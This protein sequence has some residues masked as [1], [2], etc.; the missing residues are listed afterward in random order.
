M[1]GEI[2]MKSKLKSLILY[3]YRISNWIIELLFLA[4][5][6]FMIFVLLVLRIGLWL[7]NKHIFAEVQIMFPSNLNSAVKYKISLKWLN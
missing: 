4:S 6:L 7:L 1:N 2:V 5:C 3:I